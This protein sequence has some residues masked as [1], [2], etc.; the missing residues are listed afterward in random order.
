MQF[1]DIGIELGYCYLHSFM[2]GVALDLYCLE[3]VLHPVFIFFQIPDVLAALDNGILNYAL[4]SFKI[5][6]VFLGN[7]VSVTLTII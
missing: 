1:A 4:L 3:V 7:I 5:V 2:N 6:D